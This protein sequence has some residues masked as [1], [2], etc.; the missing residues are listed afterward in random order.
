MEKVLICVNEFKNFYLFRQSLISELSKRY[1][2][3]LVGK[4][5]GYQERF[6]SEFEKVNLI[7]QSNQINP[8]NEI[9]TFISLS[10]IIFRYKPD[11][12]LTFTIKP[13]IYVGIILR[14][15]RK[16]KQIANI[17]G[18]GTTFLTSKKLK[19]IITLLY[20]ISFKKNTVFLF[21][22]AEDFK[23][24]KG[25]KIVRE[26]HA[27]IIPGSGIISKSKNPK[28]KINEIRKFI[29]AGRLIIDKGILEFI[30]AT[31]D[32]NSESLKEKF[33]FHIAGKLD[34]EN[35][36]SLDKRILDE[37]VKMN[38]CFYHG[39][40]LDLKNKLHNY[41]VMV[42]PSYREG[43]SKVLLEAG[44]NG[45]PIITTD[46]PGCKEL[47]Q[48]DNG[49]LVEVRN[50]GSLKMGIKKLIQVPD[51]E[52]LIMGNNGFKLIT[53]KYDVSNVISIYLSFLNK[54]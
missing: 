7:I 6:K 49:L 23:F 42:L 43:L 45:L 25:T 16:S 35:P 19:I 27:K 11:Y 10:R 21:Q 33:E 14:I 36:R 40:L 46:V 20:K 44:N 31:K 12:I 52:L 18:L 9:K 34:K 3:I 37:W 8:I 47:V 28:N 50:K 30:E 17:T 53:S 24:F 22:N 48:N 1:Q 32:I 5:D 4:Y 2:V 39:E 29:F 51:K 41:D 38:N 54:P 13:N 15:L 26:N